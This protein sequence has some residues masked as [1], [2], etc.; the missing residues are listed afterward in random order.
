M[1][2][3]IA[4]QIALK[5]HSGESAPGERLWSERE[6][7]ERLSVSRPSIRET[8]IA[9]EAKCALSTGRKLLL[10]TICFALVRPSAARV[11]CASSVHFVMDSMRQIPSTH[12]NKAFRPLG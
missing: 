2:L 10:L 4:D 5:T 12:L 8:L 3:T 1:Y 7:A 6:L 11:F 9:L